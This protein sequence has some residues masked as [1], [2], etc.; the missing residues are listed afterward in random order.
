M[1]AAFSGGEEVICCRSTWR[2]SAIFQYSISLIDMQFLPY[3][4]SIRNKAS[5]FFSVLAIGGVEQDTL[6]VLVRGLWS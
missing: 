4:P 5:L 6:T 1:Y 2:V 3:P